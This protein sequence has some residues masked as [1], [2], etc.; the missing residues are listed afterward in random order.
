MPATELF[1]EI[2]PCNEIDFLSVK[3]FINEFILDDTDLKREQFLLAK[4]NSELVGFVR[5]KNYSACS[6][7]CSLGVVEPHRLK[8]IGSKLVKA[9]IMQCKSPLYLVAIIPEFFT[10][11]GFYEIND[12]P[13]EILNKL[14]YCQNSLCVPESYVV[15]KLNKSIV[16]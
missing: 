13:H 2:L 11:M 16:H 6:E 7:L 1:I 3:K 4:F 15:M 12:Y 14:R 9:V 8:G 10:P 5:Q